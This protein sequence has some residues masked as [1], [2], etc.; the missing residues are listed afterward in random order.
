[1]C[2]CMCTYTFLE[3][4]CPPSLTEVH[5]CNILHTMCA[6]S[7][8]NFSYMPI[9]PS[10]LPIAVYQC[11]SLACGPQRVWEAG[12]EVFPFRK[13]QPMTISCTP[14]LTTWFKRSGPIGGPPATL[15]FI[16]GEYNVRRDVPSGN[17]FM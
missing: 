9:P 14:L 5:S 2:P 15:V 6:F 11:V 10:N 1:M 7:E 12:T 3:C 13:N 4:I 16:Y 8:M 17:S